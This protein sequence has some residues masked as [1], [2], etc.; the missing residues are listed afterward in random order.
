[1]GHLFVLLRVS[2][3]VQRLLSLIKSYL[4]VFVFIVITLG[5]G[6][7][8]ILLCFMS[9]GVRPMFSCKSFILSG[10]IFRFLIHFKFIFVYGVRKCSN[11]ILSNVVV[12]FSGLIFRSL[13]QE[14]ILNLIESQRNGSSLHGSGVNEPS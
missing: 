10:L 11:F 1:M 7:E 2:F 5:G 6:S 3:A 12:Q 4:F 8:K 13:I 14:C 9:E